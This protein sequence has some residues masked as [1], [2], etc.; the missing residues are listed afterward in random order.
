MVV[1]GGGNGGRIPEWVFQGSGFVVVVGLWTQPQ[2]EGPCGW[3]G[4]AQTAGVG[5]PVDTDLT[6]QKAETGG[7]RGFVSK[8]LQ[9]M[10]QRLVASRFA[11]NENTVS[12]K[13]SP[14]CQEIEREI[15]QII[16]IWLN[17]LFMLPYAPCIFLLRIREMK[18]LRSSNI[19]MM[20]NGCRDLPFF[21]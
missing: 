11:G 21:T 4:D 17:L 12:L 10:N 6:G 7:E 8:R 20:C 1:V 5:H 13:L 14:G 3:L 2:R 18:S 16:E 15:K 9:E 19:F